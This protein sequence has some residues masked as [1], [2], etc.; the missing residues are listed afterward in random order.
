MEDIDK[1]SS[2]PENQPTPAVTGLNASSAPALLEVRDL[3]T[4]FFTKRGVGRAVDGVSFSVAPGETLGIVGES[5]GGKSMTCLSLIGLNPKPASRIVGGQ[6]AFRGTD[7]VQLSEREMRLYRGRHI[8]MIPQDPMTA[9]NP[10]FTVGEQI[11]EQLRQLAHAPRGR[12]LKEQAV[13]YLHLMRIPEPEARLS[14]YPHQ[15]SGGMRQRV[16]GAIALSREPE[17]IIADEP[18]TALD[19]TIQAAYLELLKDIQHRSNLAIIFVTHDLGIVTHMCDRAAV[20]YAGKIVESTDTSALFSS[21]AHPYTKALLQ[22]VPDVSV[23]VKRLYSIEGQPPSIF[24]PP[25]GCRFH[26]RC[27][28]R[29][30]LGKPVRCEAEEP[31]LREILPGHVVACHFAEENLAVGGHTTAMAGEPPAIGGNPPDAC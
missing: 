1:R 8:A 3:K 9:L 6:V 27:P 26:P 18:T 17:I 5:G 22:S 23:G 19:V 4:Y 14:S 7:L 24:N 13:E 20:M 21:P 30:R 10:V 2:W 12:N 25:S 31:E 15:F 16:V 28:L 11:Y 29:Q